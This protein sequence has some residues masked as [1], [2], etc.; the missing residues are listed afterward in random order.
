MHNTELRQLHP[1]RNKIGPLH[2]NFPRKHLIFLLLYAIMY[3]CPNSSVVA[4]WWNIPSFRLLMKCT[5]LYTSWWTAPPYKLYISAEKLK[6]L[7]VCVCV[8][9]RACVRA[10][11]SACS[12]VCVCVCVCVR[13]CVC[14][15]VRVCVCICV[16]VC[17]CVCDACSVSPE[18]LRLASTS[19]LLHW[20]DRC[21]DPPPATA[22]FAIAALFVLTWAGHKMHVFLYVLFPI[23]HWNPLWTT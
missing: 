17:V 18:P 19:P 6:S 23:K 15:C 13:V 20:R 2:I 22:G 12:C 21:S 7:C 4:Q 1:E 10:C 9:V 3:D 14:V 11:V 16:C 5:I 8:C